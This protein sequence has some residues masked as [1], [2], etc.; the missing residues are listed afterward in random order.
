MDGKAFEKWE[1]A[2]IRESPDV[3]ADPDSPVSIFCQ[4][5]FVQ[6]RLFDDVGKKSAFVLHRHRKLCDAFLGKLKRRPVIV[7]HCSFVLIGEQRLQR[8]NRV[9]IVSVADCASLSL[10]LRQHVQCLHQRVCGAERFI[11]SVGNFL[12]SKCDSEIVNVLPSGCTL[13]VWSDGI[14]ILTN[15]NHR[16]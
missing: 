11:P 4:T 15:N 3:H 8:G 7:D 5:K 2:F 12:E 6:R 10:P 1:N 14:I 13:V 9:E 16:L